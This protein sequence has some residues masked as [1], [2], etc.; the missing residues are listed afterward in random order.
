MSTL[1]AV[2]IGKLRT[3][4]SSWA[5]AL[6]AIGIVVF[7][8]TLT[9]A[10]GTPHSSGDVRSLLSFAGS[11]GFIAIIF[12]I[13]S[14]AGE[15]RHRTIVPQ[16][17]VTP[18]RTRL[19]I[20]KALAFAIVGAVI[21]IISVAVTFA[22]CFPWLSA[23]GVTVDL[24]T[25]T[26]I[27]IAAGSIIYCALSAALGVGIGAIVTNQVG[28][29]VTMIVALF[30]IDPTLSTLLPGPGRFGPGAL[31]LSLSGGVAA[32]DG[33]YTSILPIAVAA[34]CFVVYTVVVVGG[35]VVATRRREIA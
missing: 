10:T 4:R 17:L 32:N 5:I 19:V 3:V 33:P 30:V 22:I 18:N 25:G 2:E 28:A 23:K 16:M 6:A 27:G 21:G 31:G 1:I 34:V 26:L 35:G 13:V 29:V 20:G 11:A 8:V 12:G 14:A 24:S 15:Y 9:L 7:S